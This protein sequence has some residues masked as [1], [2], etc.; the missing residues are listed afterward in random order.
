MKHTYVTYQI[1]KS[2][3][4][5]VYLIVIVHCDLMNSIIKQLVKDK[6]LG[7]LDIDDVSCTGRVI[8][9]LIRAVS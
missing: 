8:P 6:C 2:T 9:Q 1:V 4:L 3:W 7:A 5:Y